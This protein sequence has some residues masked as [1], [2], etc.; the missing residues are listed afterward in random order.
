[1]SLS[2]AAIDVETANPT[3]GSICSIG[4][5]LVHN[6]VRVTTRSLLCRPP[7]AVGEFG[8]RNM[9]IHRITPTMVADQ[10]EF[11]DR[12]REVHTLVGD[13]PVIAY[14]AKFDMSNV[15]RA[16]RFSGASLPEWEYGCALI[17]ARQQLQLPSYK[18]NHVTRSLG[19]NLSNHHEAGADAA[20]A[21]DVTIKLASVSGARTIPELARANRT[22][23]SRLGGARR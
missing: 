7:A 20:A 2:F 14:N 4:V 13:L 21:A 9:Q 16:C 10:P 15:E 3:Y 11:V 22:R 1:M 8:V 6:G 5:A 18:L 12:L 17:W 19:V 23:L